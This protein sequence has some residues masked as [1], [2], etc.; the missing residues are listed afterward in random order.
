MFLYTKTIVFLNKRKKF[1]YMPV[2][3]RWEPLSPFIKQACL[4]LHRIH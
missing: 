3:S 4:S 2:K 1:P